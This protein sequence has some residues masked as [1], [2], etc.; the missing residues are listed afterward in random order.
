MPDPIAFVVMPFSVKETGRTEP[1]KIDFDALWA[2]VYEPTLTAMGYQAVR[3]D[4]DVGALIISEMIQRLAL[5]DLVVADMTLPNANVYYEIGVRHAAK[6]SGCVLISADWASPLFDLAQMR[7]LRF[8]LVDGEIGEQAAE[9]AKAALVGGLAKLTAGESPVFA[10]VPG[11]P[12]QPQLD[13]VTAFKDTV[14]QLTAFE[15]DV[16]AVRLAAP[17]TRQQR[18]R[19]LLA[20]YG[21]RPV[22]R[23]V[24]VLELL[25]LVRDQLGW[26]EL[27]DYIASLPDALA[28]HPLVV[29]QRLLA[30]SETGDVAGAAGQLE[31]LIDRLGGTPERL[32][33]L[34]GRYKRL[35]RDSTGADR[36]FYLGNA[37]DAYQRGMDLDLN[38]YYAASNLPR[39]YRE[40][41]DPGDEQRALEAETATMLACRAAIAKGTADEWARPTLL[42][43][44]FERGD[45]PEAIRLRAEVAREGPAR[46]KLET[47]LADLS[48]SV[49]AR[50]DEEIRAGLK[51]V[52]DQLRDLL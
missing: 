17:G 31:A 1:A 13:R 9:D 46:W 41:N 51:A 43:L 50:A 5:A 33:L 37:I 28:D 24:V 15:G 10:A 45:V 23:D 21:A 11:F 25:R 14:T 18:V 38:E 20:Q 3:A 12:G 29:E 32:G 19:D 7:Q 27:L 22:V 40:R 26:Q 44:A 30:L 16:R 39:L 42:G 49:D 35:F 48:A 6:R 47:T 36:A 34:G 4:V 52:L 8:P 2:R